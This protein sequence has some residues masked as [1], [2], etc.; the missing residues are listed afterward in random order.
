[1]SGYEPPHYSAGARVP[2]SKLLVHWVGKG[3][4]KLPRSASKRN[5]GSTAEGQY[6]FKVSLAGCS[7][8]VHAL[9]NNSVVTGSSNGRKYQACISECTTTGGALCYRSNVGFVAGGAVNSAKVYNEL[10]T[11][12]SHGVYCRAGCRRRVRKCWQGQ[13]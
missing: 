8:A 13:Y 5:R 6:H 2:T 3:S 1:M 7:E 11:V 9:L 4:A 12:I 10:T